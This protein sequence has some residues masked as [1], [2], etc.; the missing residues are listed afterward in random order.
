MKG[1]EASPVL[2]SSTLNAVA[3]RHQRSVVEVVVNWAV[4][5]GV[6]VLP[7][8]KDPGR[9]RTNLA[10]SAF[11]LTEDDVA[12][13]DALDGVDPPRTRAEEPSSDLV[14]MVFDN[15]SPQQLNMFW[16]PPEHGDEVEIGSLAPRG[17]KLST[18]TYHTHKFNFRPADGRLA[19]A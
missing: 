2:T 14:E 4:R 11:E 18:R 13:I 5:H 1:Y 6:A 12:Q 19:Q 10:S 15:S 3:E 8:S 7:S 9:Q 17:G 16:V